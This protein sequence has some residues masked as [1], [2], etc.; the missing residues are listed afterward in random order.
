[1]PP[2]EISTPPAV[3]TPA[4]GISPRIALATSMQ[5]SPGVY[6]VLL[7]SGISSAAG[8]YTGRQIAE[9][10]ICQVAKSQGIDLNDQG[11]TPTEWWSQVGRTSLRY[12]DILEELAPTP[13]SRQALLRA[14]F[15]PPPDDPT[16]RSPTPAHRDLASLCQRGLIRVVVTTNF[17]RLLEQAL[18]DAGIPPQVIDSP[19]AVNAMTPLRHSPM[20]VIKL[21]GDYLATDLRN[22]AEELWDYPPEWQ[23]LLSQIFEEYGL[24]VVGWSAEYDRALTSAVANVRSRRYPMYWGTRRNLSEEA[25]QVVRRRDAYLIQLNSADEF[26]SDL[27]SQ[28]DRLAEAASRRRPFAILRHPLNYPDH[29][30]PP[31][32]WTVLPRLHLRAYASL[33]P[34]GTDDVGIIG[35]EIREEIL[36]SIGAADILGQLADLRSDTQC[37]NAVTSKPEILASQNS[38]WVPAGDHQSIDF[39]SY[40]WGGDATSGVCALLTVAFPT[41]NRLGGVGV[42]FDIG[43]S[44]AEALPID[45]AA[46]LLRSA[47]FLVGST[48]PSI[49]TDLLPAG[50][51]VERV[52]G[53]FA[54]SN[55][56]GIGEPGQRSNELVDRVDWTTLG[57]RPGQFGPTCGFA[58]VP[59]ESLGL[60]TASQAVVDGINHMALAHG[61][62]D[63][64]EGIAKLRHAFNLDSSGK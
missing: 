2:D 12:E 1:V 44:I 22:T 7:G 13:A 48:L 29:A 58:V 45:V 57:D 5:A 36:A 8:I 56:T 62:L 19:A 32:G 42:T 30:T 6:A 16:S 63:P 23:A 51:A 46:L 61:F 18:Y 28:V 26:F 52:E 17:D 9:D 49:M 34:V 41:V 14:Y 53:T 35:P 4:G 47:V 40:G 43:I 24:V 33:G 15:D 3:L 10:L 39:A 20:N 21:H 25:R 54:A 64:R 11:T 38:L 55:F 59:G 31:R 50:C 27:R 37:V 60:T